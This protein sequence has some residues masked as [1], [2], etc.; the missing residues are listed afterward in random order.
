M[1]KRLLTTRLT[2]RGEPVKDGGVG[3]GALPES[4]LAGVPDAVRRLLEAGVAAFA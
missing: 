2:H 1:T 4:A 3:G